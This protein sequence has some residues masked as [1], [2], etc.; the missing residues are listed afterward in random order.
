M[1]VT[2]NSVW[3]KLFGVIK[4]N[5]QPAGHSKTLVLNLLSQLKLSGERFNV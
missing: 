1:S 3:E 2:A 5:I 4:D